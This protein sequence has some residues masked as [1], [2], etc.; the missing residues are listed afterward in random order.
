M[1]RFF[2]LAVF[3]SLLAS[4]C[5][6]AFV[7]QDRVQ[8][9]LT[10]QL[11]DLT[12]GFADD[13]TRTYVEE[14]KYLRWH[15]NDLITAFYGNTLNRLYKF[16][17][18]TGDNNG[19]FSLV[20][21]GELGTGNAL[22]AIYAIYPYDSSATITDQGVMTL[23]L[24]AYQ[25]YAE[26]SFGDSANTMVAVTQNVEDTF[27]PFKNVCGY[28]KL[29]LYN[30]EAAQMKSVELTGNNGE[31][32]AG[33]ATVVVDS[34]GEPVLTMD[35]KEATTSVTVQ[36]AD[37]VY[38]G[39][40]AQTA[41]EVW[42]VLPEITFEKG[43]TIQV[44][45]IHGRIFEKSTAN[46]VA[47]ER[48]AI[49]PMEP[50]ALE[51]KPLETS[52]YV[53]R[54]TSTEQL[55]PKNL[56]VEILVHNYNAETGE[57]EIYFKER[58]TMLEDDT[59]SNLNDCHNVT[60]IELPEG[61]THL[62]DYVFYDAYDL[63][64]ISLPSTLVSIGNQAFKSTHITRVDIAD[65]RAY[66]E[67]DITGLYTSPTTN[68]AEFYVNGEELKELYI[69]DGIKKISNSLFGGCYSLTKIVVPNSVTHI[70]DY[71]FNF[72]SNVK[73]I[74]IGESVEYIGANA[75]YCDAIVYCYGPFPATLKKTIISDGSFYEPYSYWGNFGSCKIIVPLAYLDSYKDSWSMYA[76][77]IYPDYTPE[78]TDNN[79]IIY[80][81][82]DHQAVTLDPGASFGANIVAHT[83]EN[84]YGKIVFD[85]PV[86][87]IGLN[88]FNGTNVKDVML[89]ESVEL[90]AINA[91]A[92]S[93]LDSINIPAS[94]KV[95]ESDAFLKCTMT[96]V[97]LTDLSAWCKIEF[98]TTA[99]NPISCGAQIYM[100]DKLVADV[101][102][103]SDVTALKANVFYGLTPNSLTLHNGIK[104][105]AASALTNCTGKLIVDCPL[106]TATSADT[107]IFNRALF[108]E[109]VFGDSVTTI[110]A[111]S[112]P[113]CANLTSVTIGQSVTSIDQQAFYGS[114]K[115]E[116][117]YGKYVSADNRCLIKDNTLMFFAST[118]ITEYV[119]PE[120]V[121]V[122]GDYV[123]AKATALTS[124]TISEG[125]TTIGKYAFNGC[126]AL[127]KVDMPN[128]VTT[129]DNYA[130]YNCTKLSEVPLSANLTKIGTRAFY[131]CI[132]LT[133][134][135]L[136]DSVTSVGAEAFMNC[137]KVITASLGRGITTIPDYM[138]YGCTA[139]TRVNMLGDVTRIGNTAFAKCENM[140]RITIPSTV[141]YI[142]DEA[143][144]NCTALKSVNIT[145]FSAWCNIEF[146]DD[147]YGSSNPLRYGAD[148]VLNGET[149]ND[150]VIPSGITEIKANAFCYGKGITS[151]TIPESVT[152]IGKYAFS[153]CTNLAKVVL[154][155]T[156]T[157]ISTDA[158]LSCASLKEVHISDLS[159][160]C[161]T[162][163][164]NADAQPL[165]NRAALFVNGKELTDFV[166][167]A[168]VT[169]ISAY[170]FTGCSSITSVDV[171][172]SVTVIYRDA[173]SLCSN[174]KS[175]N[176]G[177]S[178]K[179][180]Y[181][182][183]FNSCA[184]LESVTLGKNISTI[185]KYAFYY[186][187]SVLTT[188]YCKATTPPSIFYYSSSGAGSFAPIA[189][190]KI[191][192]PRESY[193]AYTQ[194]TSYTSN[195][196]VQ[197]NWYIYKSYVEPYDFE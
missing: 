48:N 93:K 68:G 92:N 121:T 142:G 187:S 133:S 39:R 11:P 45:D 143:F 72:C 9:P 42:F 28:L 144:Y 52:E 51:Y 128:S 155:S 47:I 24:P 180:I 171:P 192:V 126:T 162:N 115:L 111:Y 61:L 150:I 186:S 167:P 175:V 132:A 2:F 190:F 74:H 181:E 189:G 12:A 88:A 22:D 101:V 110:G 77:S 179:T 10:E 84:G 55:V 104:S 146:Y 120:G 15:E 57:G 32:I 35:S 90:I 153:N 59:F 13:V 191:Y 50:L 147:S 79:T 37:G 125:V 31:L 86:T 182:Y 151:L 149:L 85:G 46:K 6:D 112:F 100:D 54:Y 131:N 106:P 82:T 66:F 197:N 70:G 95:I 60:S 16:N 62:G 30:G 152:S 158:F 138:F 165:R 98:D 27:L 168:D 160:W 114:T 34:A 97:H 25:D 73:E 157:K 102:V 145:D 49:Q 23:S 65:L 94:V 83:F 116:A 174:L 136:P 53:L 176:L 38:V 164:N 123:F 7:E 89:P 41:T 137:E 196:T 1:K 103:P 108:T 87:E 178:V 64:R 91:F 44:K 80:F 195:S 130:F 21:T 26:N 194:Y 134:L 119:I 113:N 56:D 188:I 3:I 78:V 172:E 109:V 69:P 141:T 122:I 18:E 36:S 129:I 118:G 140:A 17:G 117:L 169:S 96:K 166:A 127:K 105:I 8:L 58:L 184:S 185:K 177:D 33:K 163:F 173:F 43:F 81:P 75:F 14:N 154:P 139:L 67:M 29:Y 19:T 63:A 193:D 20:S 135:H 170:A 76:A 71:A 159:A 161:K 183:A 99:S 148:L 5:N 40:T 4:A 124:V 107:S 156:L